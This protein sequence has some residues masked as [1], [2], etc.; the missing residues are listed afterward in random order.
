LN[1]WYTKGLDSGSHL[2][3]SI[4]AADS[5]PQLRDIIETFFLAPPVEYRPASVGA[6]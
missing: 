3:I 2:R 6:A 5:I 1:S 4:N